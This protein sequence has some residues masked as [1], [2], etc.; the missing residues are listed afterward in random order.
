[1]S[2]NYSVSETMVDP[3]HFIEVVGEKSLEIERRHLIS[4][5]VERRLYRSSHGRSGEIKVIARY[6]EGDQTQVGVCVAYWGGSFDSCTATA[7]VSNGDVIINYEALQGLG[8]GSY[9]MNI[10]VRWLKDNAP[11]CIVGSLRL[12]SKDGAEQRGKRRNRFYGKFGFALRVDEDGAG[13]S[14]PMAVR[15]LVHFDEEPSGIAKRDWKWVFLKLESRARET[16]NLECRNACLKEYAD[17]YFRL[18]RWG[19]NIA[20]FLIYFLLGGLVLYRI[21]TW[22]TPWLK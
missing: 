10:I 5:E 22:M 19:W 16:K 4:V 3:V 21:A 13:G 11:E 12:V 15:E 9:L 20:K 18:C 6:A 7:K 14:E 8:I 2:D 1:M 17:E